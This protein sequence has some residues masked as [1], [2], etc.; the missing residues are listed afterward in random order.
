LLATFTYGNGLFSF[1]VIISIFWITGQRF[2]TLLTLI[3][4][5]IVAVI[6]FIDFKPITQNLNFRDMEQ[7]RQGFFGLFG[8]IGSVSTVSA[9]ES[10]LFFK[11]FASVSGM[12]MVISLLV[13]YR[14]YLSAIF[15]GLLG[16][17]SDIPAP[18]RFVLALALFILITALATTYKR[19]PTDT[20][21]G[22][23]KGRYR[24]YSVLS[25]IVIYL[26]I[27]LTTRYQLRS[28]FIKIAIPLAI[29]FNVIIAYFNIADIINNRRLAVAQEFNSRYNADWLGLA[30]FDMD[31]AHFEKIRSYYQSEDPLAIGWNPN[32][33]TSILHCEGES[34]ISAVFTTNDGILHIKT[35]INRLQDQGNYTEA[36]YV[37]LKSNKHVYVSAPHQTKMSLSTFLTQFTYLNP[38]INGL[39][40]T[41]TI[42]PGDYQI[43]LLEHSSGQN[44]IFC[45]GEIWV[46]H[47]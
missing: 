21:E 8:F 7:V 16:K 19:I 13:I 41:A 30:M 32:Q 18:L 34:G 5:A 36:T 22:M 38:E 25:V 47:D 17:A 43:Y 11:Y 28:L 31:Q 24:M 29:I 9:Y 33:A 10:R 2:S 26:G 12:L 6:Y 37:L 35:D 27:I 42:Q 40:H 4:A 3:I 14:N 46:E 39:F 23:F 44:K 15:N 1:A 20:F 45:T